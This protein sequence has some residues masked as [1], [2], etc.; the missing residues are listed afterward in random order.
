[1]IAEL[2]PTFSG[3]WWHTRFH[4]DQFTW[5]EPL[6]EILQSGY[7]EAFDINNAG[8]VVG[9]MQPRSEPHAFLWTEERGLTD[10]K[11][12]VTDLPNDVVLI[13]ALSINVERQIVA[14]CLK[15]PKVSRH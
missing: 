10:L 1:M 9:G 4:L 14:F 11:Q 12:V 3:R 7:S 2:L 6:N 5:N 8:Q 15:S 13:G